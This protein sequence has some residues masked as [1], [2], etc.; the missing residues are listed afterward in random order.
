MSRSDED[1]SEGEL[2]DEGMS[3]GS[4][5]DVSITDYNSSFKTTLVSLPRGKQNSIRFAPVC[6]APNYI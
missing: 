2:S 4:V 6:R 1:L 3:D 5:N